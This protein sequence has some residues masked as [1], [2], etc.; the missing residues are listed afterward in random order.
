MGGFRVSSILSILLVVGCAAPGPIRPFT[1]HLEVWPE[2]PADARIAFVGE[3]TGAADLGI[4]GSIWS[5]MI[6]LT[7]GRNAD[8]LV[9]PMAVAATLEQDKIFVADPDAGCVHRFDLGKNRYRCLTAS[10]SEQQLAPV[11]L[12][13]TEEGRVIVADSRNGE[14]WQAKPGGNTLE[15]FLVSID[16]KQ[17][18]GVFWHDETQSLFVTDTSEQV[19]YEFDQAGRLKRSIGERGSALGQLNYPTYLWVDLEGDLLV[20]DSLNFRLQ[21]FDAAG[22]PLQAFGAGGDRPGDFSRPKGVATDSFGHVYVVDALMH[23]LQIFNKQGQLLLSIGGRGQGQGEFWLPNGIFIGDDDTI[24]VAD[25][26]NRRVQ[27]FRYI[28]PAT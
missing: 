17:P 2:N 22:T 13:I 24:Y 19:I 20:T 23:M 18:T 5:R 7:M 21:R 8:I 12:A 28:G 9:R 27:V 10:G 15:R 25:A 6:G 16:L 3:F 26:Y 11:G 1:E 14:L 4:S